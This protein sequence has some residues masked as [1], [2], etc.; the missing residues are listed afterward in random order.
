[1]D[2]CAMAIAAIAEDDDELA[3]GLHRLCCV[4]LLDGGF[5]ARKSHAGQ[6]PNG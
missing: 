2:G 5:G 1:M 3:A 6:S 4:A